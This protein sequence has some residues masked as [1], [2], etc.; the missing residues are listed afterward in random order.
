MLPGLIMLQETMNNEFGEKNEA[1]ENNNWTQSRTTE[2]K[3]EY[4]PRRFLKEM[5]LSCESTKEDYTAATVAVVK[6]HARSELH[7]E[8]ARLGGLKTLSTNAPKDCKEY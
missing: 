7:S 6:T 3:A 2:G 8:V 1:T 5:F 4:D